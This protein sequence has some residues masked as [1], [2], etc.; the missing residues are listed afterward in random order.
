MQ[1]TS[2]GSMKFSDD[3]PTFVEDISTTK[4]GEALTKHV[5][6][7]TYCVAATYQGNLCTKVIILRIKNPTASSNAAAASTASNKSDKLFVDYFARNPNENNHECLTLVFL[8]WGFAKVLINPKCDPL[9]NEK[10]PEVTDL[11][12]AR[13]VVC[14]CLLLLLH[15]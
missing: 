4:L 3:A 7:T 1:E 15:A 9:Y 12:P 10:N 13:C 14:C 6:Q 8:R 11:F 2:P 5:F